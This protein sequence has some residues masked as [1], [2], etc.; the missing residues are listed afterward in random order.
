MKDVKHVKLEF[1]PA[2]YE[3]VREAAYQART[4]I[5]RWC[6]EVVARAASGITPPCSATPSST[7]TGTPASSATTPIVLASAGSARS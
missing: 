5:R 2:T 7:S 1:D 6:M 4:P 3:R